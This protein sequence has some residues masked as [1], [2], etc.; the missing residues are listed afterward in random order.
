M[1]MVY[2]P[3][4]TGMT[5]NS[6]YFFMVKEYKSNN[7]NMVSFPVTYQINLKLTKE[8]GDRAK[9]AFFVNNIFNH[10]PLY[11]NPNTDYY[12]RRNETVYFGAKK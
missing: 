6:P 7:Y 10:R 3:W 4:E 11:R 8:I 2:H 9:L 1:N 12:L 5:Y